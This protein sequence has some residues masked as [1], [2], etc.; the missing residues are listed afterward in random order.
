MRA[1]CAAGIFLVVSAV[2]APL[3]AE[4]R[5]DDAPPPRTD[6]LRGRVVRSVSLAIAP[7]PWLVEESLPSAAPLVGRPF[8]QEEVE[9][10]LRAALETGAYADGTVEA[11][12]EA[13]GLA[14]TLRLVSRRV[15]DAIDAEVSGS[16][17]SREEILRYA[18]LTEGQS[19]S[20]V[21]VAEAVRRVGAMLERRGYTGA[22]VHVRTR[23]TDRANRLAFLVRVSGATERAIRSRAV[24]FARPV[25]HF[26]DGW[27]E[28][29]PPVGAR[30]DEEVLRELAATF[31]ERLRAA[32][33]FEAEAELRVDEGGRVVVDVRPGALFRLRFEGVDRF[34]GDT[35]RKLADFSSREGRDGAAIAEAVA[36]YYGARGYLDVEVRAELR[37]AKDGR[38]A[39]LVLIVDEHERVPIVAR[40]FPRFE[41]D[42][43]A[44]RGAL[45]RTLAE[46]DALGVEALRE[47]LPGTPVFRPV[48]DERANAVVVR[49]ATGEETVE[50]LGAAFYRPAYDALREYLEESYRNEGF[51]R[52]TAGPVLVVRKYCTAASPLGCPATPLAP[53]L[54]E[55]HLEDAPPTCDPRDRRGPGCER[56]VAVVMPVSLGPRTYVAEVAFSGLRAVSEPEAS[57]VLDLRLGEPAST[58]VFQGAVDRLVEYYREQGYAFATARFVI[59][60]SPNRELGRVRFEVSEGP[61]VLVDAIVLEGNETLSEE[62]LRGRIALEVGKPYRTSL[63]RQSREA[64]A[65]LPAVANVTVALDDTTVPSARQRVIVSLR[66]ARRQIIEVRPGA[67]TGEG[68]RTSLEYTHRNLLSYGISASTRV[69]LSYLP[70][71]LLLDSVAASNIGALDMSER[72]VA[73]ATAGVAFPD[74]GLGTTV[75]GAIDLALIRDLQ[76]DFRLDKRSLSATLSWLPTPQWR[77]AFGPLV[78]FNTIRLFVDSASVEDYLAKRAAET[79]GEVDINLVRLLRIPNGSSTVIGQKFQ[80]AYD[81]RDNAFNARRGVFLAAAVEHVDSFPD[82]GA[83]GKTRFEGHFFRLSETLGAYVPLPFGVTWATQLRL[84]QVAHLT[85]LGESKTYPDR[86]FFLGG[87][88]SVR[89]YL[90]DAFVPQDLANELEANPD[91]SLATVV[92]RG[93]NLFVNPRTELRIPIVGALGTV[94]FLDA[95]NLWQNPFALLDD[96]RSFSLRAT[97]G[98]GVRLDTPLFPIAIDVG[99]NLAPRRWEDRWAYHF[100]VG[101]F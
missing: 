1:S 54:L 12:P 95:A 41:S 67:S 30:I 6:A 27:A 89:G 80:V 101:L 26:A 97:A 92:S 33:Y 44:Q 28:E 84:G 70:D 94:A 81:A 13:E 62:L 32:G 60:A 46:L 35:L 38:L 31:Q 10:L 69:Q 58:V 55:G 42:A 66:E 59:E 16:G 72:L 64:L 49:S 82:E 98:S 86:L 14:I 83:D 48:T 2:T 4:V 36:A 90:Q 63:A 47:D 11:V 5:A 29:L 24:V 85:R 78:E 57:R 18:A 21:D 96:P 52:A 50:A 74:V 7:A 77:L 53:A 99:W 43:G 88:D 15:V 34:D 75:R 8:R 9:D 17:P 68:F 20:S 51:L 45:P 23:E 65:A 76:R 61:Q 40:S 39:D 56:A 73:R 87:M 25:G 71:F 100:A 22:D 91:L 79:G 93:G 19:A 3:R 37:R